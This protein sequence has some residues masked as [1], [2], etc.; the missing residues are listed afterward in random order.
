M[1]SRNLS[2]DFFIYLFEFFDFRTLP[3][4]LTFNVIN[5]EV[6]TIETQAFK[7]LMAKINT[8]A[9][10]VA[11]QQ[12]KENESPID[13][14]VDSHEVCTY[15]KISTRTLQRLRASR[16]VNYSLIR[17]KTFYRISEIQRLMDDNLIRRTEEHLQEL[18]K[19]HHFHVEQN[20]G[21]R[22]RR[23]LRLAFPFRK[24]SQLYGRSR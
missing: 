4:I 6:I 11:A 14:W 3:K 8:I 1:K 19:N 18:I 5:M 20:T 2:K 21:W 7:D 22:G 24:A 23:E 9:K 12:E 15:L 16:S 13:D 10:Y 17:G